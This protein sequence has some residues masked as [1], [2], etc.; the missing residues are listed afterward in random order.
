MTTTIDDVRNS[1][2]AFMRA[3]G[4]PVPAQTATSQK[5]HLEVW[6]VGPKR[7]PAGLEMKHDGIVNIWV[8]SLNVPPS[9][10]ADVEAT[11]KTPKGR[12]WTDVNG[13]GAN[14]N[15]S[16]YDEFRTKPIVRLGVTSVPDAIAIL[17]HLNR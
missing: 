6:T 12:E 7:R 11:R 2:L 13:K 17:N 16:S 8:T 14:S 5:E 4:K 10:S 15:L 3:H 1:I 9:L